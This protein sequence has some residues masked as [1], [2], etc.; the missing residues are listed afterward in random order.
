MISNRQRTAIAIVIAAAFLAGCSGMGGDMH[1]VIAM[2]GDRMDVQD[3]VAN[4][5][6]LLVTGQYGLAI[7]A[8]SRVL[9]DDPNNVRA[10]NLIAEAYDRLHRYDLADRYHAQALEVDPNSVAAL[11]NWGF[12]Y[13]VRG[14]KSRAIELLERAEA[15]KS[16]Q[17]IVLANL[18]LAGGDAEAPSAVSTTGLSAG[19]DATDVPVSRHVMLVRRT[20]NLVRIAPGVQMLVTIAP[21]ASRMQPAP[22]QTAWQSVTEIAPL[23]YIVIRR[24]PVDIDTRA[25]NLAAL[26]RLLDP[27]LFGL[28]RDVDDFSLTSGARLGLAVNSAQSIDPAGYRPAS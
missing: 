22:R 3:P 1:P 11:N 23:P 28:L 24:H 27:S 8:L 12:S 19:D 25:R 10:L 9:H 7:D 20:A 2:D 17:P 16:D 26:Q 18:K 5:R 14:N 13:L 21:A 15:I 6:A 4:G